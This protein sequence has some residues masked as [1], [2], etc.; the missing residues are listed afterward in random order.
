MNCLFFSETNTRATKEVCIYYTIHEE[1][2]IAD[3]YVTLSPEIKKDYLTRKGQVC[4]ELETSLPIYRLITNIPQ[5]S[6]ADRFGSQLE[7]VHRLYNGRINL[8]PH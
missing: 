4:L 5:T 8:N 6:D 2:V 3:E 1:Q 7:F